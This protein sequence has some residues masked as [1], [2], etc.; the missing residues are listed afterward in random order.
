MKHKL[1]IELDGASLPTGRQAMVNIIEYRK[2][3]TG[4][5]TLRVLDSL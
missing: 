1:I 3:R 5:N 4:I 2:M